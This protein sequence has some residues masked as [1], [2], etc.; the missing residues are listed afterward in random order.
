MRECLEARKTKEEVEGTLQGL[1]PLT[2]RRRGEPVSVL[3][4]IVYSVPTPREF[5][6]LH[7]KLQHN[8]SFMNMRSFDA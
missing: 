7:V 1:S 3:R 4:G 6:V 2:R 5:A 8:F